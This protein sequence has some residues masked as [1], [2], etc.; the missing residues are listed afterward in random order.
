MHFKF[1]N[2]IAS[3]VRA[4]N[5]PKEH[6]HSAYRFHQ[7]MFLSGIERIISVR[8][9]RRLYASR[10]TRIHLVRPARSHGRRRPPTTRRSIL[11]SLGMSRRPGSLESTSP[12]RSRA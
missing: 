5:L 2:A 10:N 6:E 12:G 11:R 3:H 1:I 7:D 9:A 4:L 8:P